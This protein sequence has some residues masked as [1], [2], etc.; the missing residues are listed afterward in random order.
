MTYG[1]PGVYVS[2]SLLPAPV[3]AVGGSTAAGA[4]LGA[5]PQGPENVTLVRSWY[6]F[7]RQFGGY[8]A[9]FPATFGVAQFFNNTGGDLYVKRVL[10]SGAAA[11]TVTI[12]STTSGVNLGTATAVNR[13]DAGNNL[14]IQI[15]KVGSGNLFNLTVYKEV[16]A[17]ELGTN[18]A[19]ATNDLIVEQYLSVVFNDSTSSSYAPTL[20][21][22]VSAYITLS[23]TA[24]TPAVQ[25]VTSVLPLTGGS[26]GSAPVAADFGNVIP[27]DGSS[28]FDALDRPLVMFAPELAT[29]FALDGDSAAEANATTVDQA[30]IAWAD[31]GLGF[32]VIE[33]AA[34]KTVAQ[35]IAFATGL[36]ASSHAAVYYPHIYVADPF[37]RSGNTL[38]K[39]GPA[40]SIAG[41]YLATDAKTGPFKAPAGIQAS[42][43][44]AVSL[45]RAFTPSDLDSLNTGIYT[46]GGTTHYGTS[47]NAIRNI[48][49]AGIVSMGARTLLQD[50][51]ANK[52]VN[53]RRSLIFIEKRLRDLTQFAIFQN[54]DDKLWAQLTTVISVF[55]NE[56]R[57]Q[58]GLRGTS[59]SQAYFIKIDS[60]NNTAESV[61]NG[62][63]HISVGV[64]LEYPAEFIVINLSQTTGF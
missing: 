32:A 38:R 50:G 44:G 11:A 62:E 35:A 46:T 4:V 55:L 43:R 19:N 58:G 51:T 22:G 21:N 64:A 61:A 30:M 1:R 54:N 31:A 14:R 8:N 13:G 42:V 12:P 39:V 16:A 45:E 20:I 24:G 59:P 5:F 28:D 52:Y 49:G 23:I 18:N 26:D 60:E 2:E 27:T 15:S 53:M 9:A 37:S 47:V 10:G 48:P 41:L 56:Y 40:G 25:S 3:V 6:D 34:G 29:K 36:T 7:T 57:N 63:V 17:G 33:T